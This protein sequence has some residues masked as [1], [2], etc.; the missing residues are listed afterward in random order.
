MLLYDILNSGYL[1]SMY[2]VGLSLVA[3][4]KF[5]L[6]LQWRESMSSIISGRLELM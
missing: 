2:V 1:L 4:R 6:G 3:S 5:M